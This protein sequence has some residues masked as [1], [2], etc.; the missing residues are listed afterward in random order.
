MLSKLYWL[1]KILFFLL[2]RVQGMIAR[3][4]LEKDSQQGETEKLR[5]EHERVQG[6]LSKVQAQYDK[7]QAALDKAQMDGDRS[8]SLAGER[9]Y[10]R[11]DFVVINSS[12]YSMILYL[13]TCYV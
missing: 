2:G 9:S 3:Y 1:I 4:H 12:V 5:S 7:T 13:I 6:T 10:F 11:F 8:A